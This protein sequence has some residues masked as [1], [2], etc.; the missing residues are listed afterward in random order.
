VPKDLPLRWLARLV[1]GLVGLSRWSVDADNLRL[2]H[3]RLRLC[4]VRCTVRLRLCSVR[5]L[6]LLLHHWLIFLLIH[7]ED[8]PTNPTAAGTVTAS[9]YEA[10]NNSDNRRLLCDFI[11]FRHVLNAL[12]VSFAR[13]RNHVPELTPTSAV[14]V[15]SFDYHGVGF[16]IIS[17]PFNTVPLTASGPSP[18]VLTWI[19]S[20]GG[21]TLTIPRAILIGSFLIR[22][23]VGCMLIVA[24]E[25]YNAE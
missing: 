16:L 22:L 9:P 10:G 21:C 15:T 17:E 6:L 12:V 3:V 5:L 7:E 13:P 24:L 19:V 23:P 18:A 20:G 4:F 2:H 11:T 1:A 8:T 25:C 14:T